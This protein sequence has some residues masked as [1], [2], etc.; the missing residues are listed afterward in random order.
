MHSSVDLDLQS[1]MTIVE[2][3]RMRCHSP[4]EEMFTVPLIVLFTSV[5]YLMRLLCMVLAAQWLASDSMRRDCMESVK[6][7]LAGE[8]E[9]E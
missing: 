6:Q 9:G 4:D 8:E 7:A 5:W 2:D 1:V 3:D